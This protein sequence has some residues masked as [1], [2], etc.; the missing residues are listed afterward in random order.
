MRSSE[1]FDRAPVSLGETAARRSF[2]FLDEDSKTD[3]LGGLP[4][5]ADF[6]AKVGCGRLMPI[7]IRLGATGFDL[8]APTLV[9]QLQRYAAHR[10]VVGGGRATSEANRRRF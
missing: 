1:L 7:S 6:V 8:P 9:T 4:L 3:I 10:A 5:M 2:V